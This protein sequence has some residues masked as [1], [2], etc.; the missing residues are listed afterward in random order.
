VANVNNAMFGDGFGYNNSQSHATDHH[1]RA[2]YLNFSVIR[3]RAIVASLG[4]GV[5]LE[6]LEEPSEE[7]SSSGEK[8][9]VRNNAKSEPEPEKAVDNEK[10]KKGNRWPVKYQVGIAA[11]MEYLAAEVL[12]LSAQNQK[13]KELLTMESMLAA[14]QT[15]E[16]ELGVVFENCA[17]LMQ[18]VAVE[19]ANRG[20]E[21][22]ERLDE[23]AVPLMLSKAAVEDNM[24][25][26]AVWMERVAL[27]DYTSLASD[28]L[29]VMTNVAPAHVITVSASRLLTRLLISILRRIIEANQKLQESEQVTPPPIAKALELVLTDQLFRHA[30]SEAMKAM[31]RK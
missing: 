24:T 30:K 6:S 8:T 9:K 11:V 15:D 7:S 4:L 17:E 31:T 14:I 13:N 18:Q 28:F 21:N 12:E 5:E 2:A 19:S 29:R 20:E 23:D 27:G 26:A 10:E 3:I 25:H 16:E 22:A 1:S